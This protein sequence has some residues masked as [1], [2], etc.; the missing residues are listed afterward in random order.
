MAGYQTTFRVMRPE[1]Q[2][3]N[4]SKHYKLFTLQ[5]D[6]VMNLTMSK[7]GPVRGEAGSTDALE[8]M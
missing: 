5:T 8:P 2:W 3:N 6:R 4:K 7:H 1:Q